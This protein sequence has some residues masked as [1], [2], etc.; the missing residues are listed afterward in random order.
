MLVAFV[1]VVLAVRDKTAY[2]KKRP[3]TVAMLPK[4][5]SRKLL[6]SSGT[7]IK[8]S[9]HLGVTTVRAPAKDWWKMGDPYMGHGGHHGRRPTMSKRLTPL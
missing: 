5:S 8:K 3:D 7:A 2:I 4:S 9:S 6:P 1:M